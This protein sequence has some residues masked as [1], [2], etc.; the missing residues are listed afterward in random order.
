MI[1]KGEIVYGK[2]TNILG[3]GAFV[4]VDNYDGLIHISEFSDNFVRSIKDYVTVGQ[5]VKLKVLDVDEEGKRLRLSYK[6]L[7]KSRGVKGEIP[8]YTI[9]F[10]SLEKAMP[11][12]ISEQF[13]GNK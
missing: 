5:Q 4:T 10:A 13:R 12:F 9:G 2:V 11:K 3:Y 8:K 1:K 6:A 7:N